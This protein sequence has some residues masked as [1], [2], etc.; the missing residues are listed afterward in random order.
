VPKGASIRRFA[1][2]F[3]YM[4]LPCQIYFLILFQW[5][6]ITIKAL[7]GI[8]AHFY[9]PHKPGFPAVIIAILK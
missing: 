4:Q 1:L 5:V 2:L 3:N 7:W 8:N 9:V 6:I